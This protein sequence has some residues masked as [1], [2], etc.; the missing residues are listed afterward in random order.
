MYTLFPV[1]RV[2]CEGEGPNYE[3]ICHF[4][5]LTSSQDNNPR[6]N[7][8]IVSINL[9][10][11]CL[12]ADPVIFLSYSDLASNI[13][14][15]VRRTPI[16]ELRERIYHNG[17]KIAILEFPPAFTSTNL[18]DNQR[19]ILDGLFPER[20]LYSSKVLNINIEVVDKGTGIK[21]AQYFPIWEW[22]PSGQLVSI[23][24]AW[25]PQGRW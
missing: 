6:C 4:S 17:P 16:Y 25:A 11:K 2:L 12:S 22:F 8:L 9:K 5:S 7:F 13:F 23:V 24:Y 19:D 1:V 10:L 21:L 20:G 18:T 14:V 3:Y 15:P